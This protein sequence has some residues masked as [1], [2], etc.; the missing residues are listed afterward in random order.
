MPRRV[1]QRPWQASCFAMVPETSSHRAELGGRRGDHGDPAQENLHDRA[2]GDEERS[3]AEPGSA[4]RRWSDDS[5]LSAWAAGAFRVLVLCNR[6]RLR[7][8]WC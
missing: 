3:E 6:R 7:P 4:S 5:R 1:S 8:R 2:H